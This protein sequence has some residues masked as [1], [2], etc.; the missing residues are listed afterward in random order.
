MVRGNCYFLV[1][2]SQEQRIVS[3]KGSMLTISTGPLRNYNS[4][5][6]E[7]LAWRLNIQPRFSLV[8]YWILA[9]IKKLKI[10]LFQKRK[11]KKTLPNLMLQKQQIQ[12][13][14]WLLYLTLFHKGGRVSGLFLYISLY[15]LHHVLCF[16]FTPFLLSAGNL[17]L[18]PSTF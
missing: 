1:P 4:V 9:I 11:I 15:P 5:A 16:C 17:N 7:V 13:S 14:T 3:K 18:E 12:I 10:R 6:H 8:I 2:F